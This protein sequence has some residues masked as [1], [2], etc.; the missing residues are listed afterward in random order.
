M[1]VTKA[2]KIW[3]DYHKAH[4]KKKIPCDRISPLLND[5]AR[6]SVSARFNR[7]LRMTSL[8]S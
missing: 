7:L 3:I 1:K 4:S 6:I 5:S 8:P 2:A